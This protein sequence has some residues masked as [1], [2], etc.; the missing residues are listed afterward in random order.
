MRFDEVAA[1]LEP[2]PEPLPPPLDA[3]MPVRTDGGT[4]RVPGTSGIPA[5]R[6][7]AV[8]VLV[9]PD[10]AGVARVVLIERPSHDDRHHSG[11]VSFPVARPSRRT[12]MPSRPRCARRPRR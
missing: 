2:L 8:L 12:R 3:L 1:R 11:E 6:P 9:Y 4:W 7:A 5:G 10:Y